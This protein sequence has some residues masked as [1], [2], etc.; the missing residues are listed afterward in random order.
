[1]G[2]KPGDVEQDNGRI[3]TAD[4]PATVFRLRRDVNKII[5]AYP[6]LNELDERAG[7]ILAVID[8]ARDAEQMMDKF[9]AR[10]GHSKREWIPC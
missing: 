6:I 1:M 9:R 5:Q 2:L 4:I 10:C 8:N 7:D 3:S